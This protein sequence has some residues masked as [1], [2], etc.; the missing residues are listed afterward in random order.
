VLFLRDW[1]SLSLGENLARHER[2]VVLLCVDQL[3]DL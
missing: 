2:L 1:L 3:L